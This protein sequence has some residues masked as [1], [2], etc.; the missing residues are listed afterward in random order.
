MDTSRKS[1]NVSLLNA[2][3][4][5]VLSAF[6]EDNICLLFR[7]TVKTKSVLLGHFLASGQVNNGYQIL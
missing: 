4:Q 3:L 2:V 1:F 5:S 6:K 7:L